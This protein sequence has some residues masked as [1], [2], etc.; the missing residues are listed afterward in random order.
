MGERCRACNE[1]L[2]AL[3]RFCPRCG[4]PSAGATVASDAGATVGTGTLTDPRQRMLPPRVIAAA[5]VA[6][7]GDVRVPIYFV[8]LPEGGWWGGVRAL[9]FPEME[10]LVLA[11]NLGDAASADAWIMTIR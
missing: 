10:K 1:A 5:A 2:P 8:P 11:D 7:G 9:A 6:P 3:A 4:Q